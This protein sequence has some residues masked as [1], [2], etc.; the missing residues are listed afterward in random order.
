MPK[1]KNR[2][3]KLGWMLECKLVFSL[4]KKNCFEELIISLWINSRRSSW[5]LGLFVMQVSL[6][7]ASMKKDDFIY[8]A[9]DILS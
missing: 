5:L 3:Q 4:R 9:S 1:L 2:S 6:T 8:F 7:F